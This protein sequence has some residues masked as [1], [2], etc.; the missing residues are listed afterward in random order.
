M[1]CSATIERDRPRAGHG[2]RLTMQ[3][4]LAICAQSTPRLADLVMDDH[5]RLRGGPDLN[6]RQQSVR[7]VVAD[8]VLALALHNHG[9]A[10]SLAE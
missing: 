1:V 7:R 6:R 10:V 8:L 4:S 5:V 3:M 9:I 2:P